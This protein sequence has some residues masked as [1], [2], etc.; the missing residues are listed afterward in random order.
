MVRIDECIAEPALD[1]RRR[2]PTAT[3]AVLCALLAIGLTAVAPPASAALPDDDLAIEIRALG[4]PSKDK[5]RRTAMDLYNHGAD[6]RAALPALSAALATDREADVREM[7]AQAIRTVGVGQPAAVAP[8]SL[9]LAADPDATV[10]LEAAKSLD[11][12]ALEPDGAVPALIGALRDKDRDVRFAVADALGNKAFAPLAARSVPALVTALGD[13]DV[14]V[15]VEVIRALGK[16]GAA[17]A[18]SVPALRAMLGETA[19][20]T[21]RYW[22]LRALA[23]IGP[24]AGAAA[25]ECRA[26]LDDHDKQ[27]QL[28]AAI[29]LL[30]FGMSEPRAMA[31][32]VAALSVQANGNRLGDEDVRLD[33]IVRAAGA[34][35]DFAATVPPGAVPRLGALIF[36]HSADVRRAAE[37]AFDRVL[38]A[39]VSAHRTDAISDLETTQRALQA[40][41][42]DAV[43]ALKAVAVGESIAA[44]ERSRPT[45]GGVPLRT[46]ALALLAAFAALA[47]GGLALLRRR[48]RAAASASA[49]RVL[50][51]YRRSD[52]AA[53]CGRVY[54]RLVM[55]WGADH[56]FRDIDSLAPGEAF[57]ERIRAF[58]AES[59]AV[60]VLIGPQ[61]LA[62]PAGETRGRLHDANDFVRLEIAEALRQEKG[63]IPVLHDGATMPSSEQ[64]PDDI[65]ALAERNAIELSDRHFTTDVER[66]MRALA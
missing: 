36:D 18:P 66:L 16:I 26:A 3:A 24:A 48:R 41:G 55:H 2:A 54:D 58:V 42:D 60:L 44:I 33:M 14:G 4:D 7:I 29:A 56:V 57:A 8:L 39:F 49:P 40:R 15:G 38:A 6:A 37:R 9:A 1:G 65:A 46:A 25:P 35:G 32:L 19:D 13:T 45:I 52:S 47:V 20:T 28:G 31:V 61:W 22:A 50:L 64:L 59:D 63:L 62:S 27:I 17:A 11:E 30:S 21:H 12:L 10:R 5:R 53:V 51:S 43:A 34:L 23:G